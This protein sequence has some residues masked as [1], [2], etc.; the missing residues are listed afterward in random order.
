[1][2][3][4]MRI[5]VVPDPHHWK[6]R[7]GW[8]FYLTFYTASLAPKVPKYLR[9]STNWSW[10][11]RG[12]PDCYLRWRSLRPPPGPRVG[13][14]SASPGPTSSGCSGC[15]N[16]WNNYYYCFLCAQNDSACPYELYLSTVRDAGFEPGI[17][18]SAAAEKYTYTVS[19]THTSHNPDATLDNTGYPSR[20]GLCS[21]Q[22]IG[23]R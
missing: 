4:W 15:H 22:Y 23:I 11:R 6:Y 3:K 21:K 5:H 10:V 12:G 18:A 7:S 8:L 17:S 20:N 19:G 2:T 9:V 14:P 13:Q 1:M 16:R